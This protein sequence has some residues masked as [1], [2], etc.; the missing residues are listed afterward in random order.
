[1]EEACCMQQRCIAPHSQPLPTSIS[2]GRDRTA[3]L[4][5][6]KNNELR[7]VQP[8]RW[9][10][11]LARIIRE[12]R[13]QKEGGYGFP[14]KSADDENPAKPG[15]SPSEN[16]EGSKFPRSGLR[17]QQS[18]R[19]HTKQRPPLRTVGRTVLAVIH[20]Q[21]R[22]LARLSDGMDAVETSS[23]AKNVPRGTSFG[24]R[25]D[26]ERNRMIQTSLQGLPGPERMVY[27]SRQGEYTRGTGVNHGSTI[28]LQANHGGFLCFGNTANCSAIGPQYNAI[29]TA[30]SLSCRDANVPLTYGD[31]IILQTGRHEIVGASRVLR[32]Q[33]AGAG[34]TA[35]PTPQTVNFRGG[36]SD[37]AR[38]LGRW[39]LQK[40]GDK[41]AVGTEVRHLDQVGLIPAPAS[42]TSMSS[43]PALLAL[44][45]F[46][47]VILHQQWV[48]L[49]SNN[50]HDAVLKPFMGGDDTFGSAI[51]GA[52]EGTGKDGKDVDP[53][54][55]W[56]ICLVELAT[57]TQ[58]EAE[59]RLLEQ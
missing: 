8:L 1:M 44:L 9:G 19:N 53:S 29:M 13:C 37:K 2:M 35:V 22:K 36:N 51:L 15:G 21:H 23:A 39:V 5:D 16:R 34:G 20:D 6:A 59:G 12:S 30:W 33:R 7:Q 55:V 56:R 26:A 49:A 52:G 28:A 50:P 47:Q 4:R 27:R 31:S 24:I 58:E 18:A 14:A 17:K 38:S 57:G 40:C 10:H 54:C 11:S 45:F 25:I 46:T 43:F 32:Q 48:C 42:L 3:V 41:G